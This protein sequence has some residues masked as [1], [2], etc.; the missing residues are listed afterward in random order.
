MYVY[1]NVY[2][3]I[4]IVIKLLGFKFFL[5]NIEFVKFIM[6]MEI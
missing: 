2:I 4:Y 6:F 5:I 3:Y 1:V